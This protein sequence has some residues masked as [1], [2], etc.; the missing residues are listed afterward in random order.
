[1]KLLFLIAILS[2]PFWG[3]A[4]DENWDV[5]TGKV[6]IN[7]PM[8]VSILLERH[9][10]YI[11]KLEGIPGY[12]IQVAATNTLREINEAKKEFEKEFENYYI[13]IVFRNPNYK[14]QIGNYRSR[15]Q[16]Y[17][18]LMKIRKEFPQSFISR[19]PIDV[20]AP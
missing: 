14:L 10:Q 19:G 17:R 15:I 20:T 9:R 7:M 16:A 1:M 4:Q 18:H 5:D 13:D 8:E 12:R 3:T 11:E 2:L 6:V